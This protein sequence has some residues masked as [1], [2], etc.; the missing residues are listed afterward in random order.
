MGSGS[1]LVRCISRQGGSLEEL[2]FSSSCRVSPPSLISFAVTVVMQSPRIVPNRARLC[3]PEGF[4]RREVTPGV[5]HDV[6]LSSSRY[7]PPCGRERSSVG[8]PFRSVREILFGVSVHCVP[9]V[10][11]IRLFGITPVGAGVA[12][13]ES[14]VL[15][16]RRVG[17]G[18]LL[19]RVAESCSGVFRSRRCWC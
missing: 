15:R 14:P 7:H 16:L 17:V 4:L 12:A 10:C 3:I 8:L 2:C 11:G 6:T 1:A 18:V 9:V 13:A 19:R 5:V